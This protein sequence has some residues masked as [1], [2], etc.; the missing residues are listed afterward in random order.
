MARLTTR[1]TLLFAAITSVA[2]AAPQGK[3]RQSCSNGATVGK[4]VYFITNEAT[5][6]VVALPIGRDGRISKGSKTK[7]GGAGKPA[8]PDALIGQSALTVAGNVRQFSP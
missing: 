8:T 4:A 7:T 5:N 6:A 1:L 3:G 2:E